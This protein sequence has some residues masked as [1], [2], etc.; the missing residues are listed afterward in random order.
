M[1]NGNINEVAGGGAL[2]KICV[3]VLPVYQIYFGHGE[4]SK[5]K[6]EIKRVLASLK[7]VLKKIFLICIMSWFPKH[8]DIEIMRIFTYQTQNDDIYT[9][10]LSETVLFTK[11]FFKFCV[12][13]LIN[14]LSTIHIRRENRV[15]R[16][17]VWKG[18]T[19]LVAKSVEIGKQKYM[20]W[21]VMLGSFLILLT[22][23][24]YGIWFWKKSNVWKQCDY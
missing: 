16:I 24:F 1:N 8:I 5:K 4:N 2:L 18:H 10:H 9:K 21:N 15:G 11:Q 17:S 3:M 12:Q 7:C 20:F 13:F 19:R 23:L 14:I 22:I 6:R